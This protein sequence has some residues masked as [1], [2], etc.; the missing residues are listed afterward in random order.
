MPVR[1][2]GEQKTAEN[3][4]SFLT[5]FTNELTSYLRFWPIATQSGHGSDK[6]GLNFR[7]V[8]L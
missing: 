6:I 7:D 3:M 5:S 2:N 8:L 4:V 1:G